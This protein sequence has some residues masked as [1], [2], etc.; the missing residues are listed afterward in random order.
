MTIRDEEVGLQLL[1]VKWNVPNAVGAIDHAQ[2]TLF[3]ADGSE[4]LKG[5][6]TTGVTDNGVENSSAN[7]EALLASLAHDFTEPALELVLGDRE[8]KAHLPRLE[9]GVLLQ[10]DNAFLHGSVHRLEVNE[11][12]PGLEVQV[13][14]DRCD[15]SGSV[16][17]EHALLFRSI[18]NPRDGCARLVEVLC[19]VCPNIRVRS[20]LGE[21]HEGPLDITDRGGVC[22]ERAC[23]SCQIARDVSD[24]STDRG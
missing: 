14:Q 13:I 5:E 20:P 2:N 8:F 21:V 17:H 24:T 23:L 10:G 18:E 12:L 11:G 6:S 16:L 3:P 1:H 9:I 4:S 15:A 7:L 19:M 22:T